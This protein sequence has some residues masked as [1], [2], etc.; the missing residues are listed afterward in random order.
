MPKSKLPKRT[1]CY[2]TEFKIQAVKLSLLPDL[3]VQE[4]AEGLGI[5]PFMLS[6][7]RKQYR[8]H[9]LQTR[10]RKRANIVVRK[11]KVPSAKKLSEKAEL[12]KEIA[13]LKKENDLLKKWQRYLGEQHQ[14]DL[15]SSI[16]TDMK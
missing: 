8:E 11:K 13:R 12:R 16:D 9:I 10:G 15:D 4:I 1:W 7:W 6:R 5:N 14:A 3:Q 2:S